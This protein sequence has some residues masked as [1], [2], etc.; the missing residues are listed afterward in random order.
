MMLLFGTSLNRRKPSRDQAGP[1][2]NWKPVATRSICGS[3]DSCA[4][5]AAPMAP[6]IETP[7]CR[8]VVRMLNLLAGDLDLVDDALDALHFFR[9]FFRSLFLLIG[10]DCSTQRDD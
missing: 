1:S 6:R 9:Q 7:N 5:A 8:R 3:C 2:V 4:R 10:F